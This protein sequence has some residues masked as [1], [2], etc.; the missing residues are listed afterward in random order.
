MRSLIGVSLLALL[1]C[2]NDDAD[3]VFV[4]A[5]WMFRSV[6]VN[7]AQTCPEGYGTVVVH[8]RTTNGARCNAEGDQICSEPNA[9]SDGMGISGRL[10]PNVY[11]VWLE[12]TSETGDSVYAVTAPE[13]IDLTLGDKSYARQILVDGGVFDVAWSL[14]GTDGTPRSCDQASVAAVVIT[15]SDEADPSSA[16]AS[17]IPCDR[18]RGYTL[19]Y[20]AGSYTVSLEAVDENGQTRG[21]SDTLNG[22]VV[23]APNGITDLG[24]IA[25]SLSAAP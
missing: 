12:V 20:L 9:C 6:T 23:T 7:T 14:R 3:G 15:T 5:T 10:L 17:E 18:G 2:G 19:P 21:L 8:A 13:R 22:Q 11:E 24:T 1:G 25:I 16:N 4:T